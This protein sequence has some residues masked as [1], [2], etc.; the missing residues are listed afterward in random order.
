MHMWG[1]G[2]SE[3][4]SAL[5]GVGFSDAWSDRRLVEFVLAV[6]QRALNR[7]GDEKRL[8][9]RAVEPLLPPDVRQGM[10]KTDPYPLYNRALR[11][12]AAPTIEYLLSG[13]RAASREWLDGEALESHYRAVVEGAA[14]HH[15]LWWAISTEAWV[16]AFHEPVHTGEDL[17]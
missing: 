10:T 8:V 5:R 7:V 15:S 16:R 14:E 11:A 2:W 4:M 12:R 9:R 1:V 6:P 17:L 13:S 3:R